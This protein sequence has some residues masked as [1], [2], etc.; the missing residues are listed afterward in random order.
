MSLIR[1][2]HLIILMICGLAAG[3]LAARTVGSIPLPDGFQRV[4]VDS[5]SFG[6]WLRTLPLLPPASPVLDY[7][8]RIRKGAADSTVAAVIDLDIRG[9]KLMQCMDILLRLRSDYL[10]TQGRADEIVFHLPDRT[11]LRWH[12]WR[13]GWRPRQV[14]S[15]FPLRQTAAADASDEAFE[16][17]LRTIFYHSHTQIFYHTLPSVSPAELRPGDIII[18]RGTRGHAVIILDMARNAAGDYLALFA[19]G[20][21]PACQLHILSYHHGQ[22][23]IPLDFQ[24]DAPPLP[25]GKRMLWNGLRRFSETS[26]GEDINNE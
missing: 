10:R 25:I 22:P 12:D 2:Y 6:G 5:N 26:T 14:G 17:Y 1:F 9:R 13:H 4:A 15:D 19:Q 7:R 20:D 21:T 18:K 24:Q 11:P 16:H 3:P 8:G 23:W